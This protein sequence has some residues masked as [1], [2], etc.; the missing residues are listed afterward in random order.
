MIHPRRFCSVVV[1]TNDATPKS[2]A[3]ILKHFDHSYRFFQLLS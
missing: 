1:L 2:A 3:G